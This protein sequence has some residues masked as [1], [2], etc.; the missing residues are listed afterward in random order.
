MHKHGG[1]RRAT[2]IRQNVGLESIAE[3]QEFFGLGGESFYN[4]DNNNQPF[5]T[6]KMDEMDFVALDVEQDIIDSLEANLEIVGTNKGIY[7][8]PNLTSKLEKTA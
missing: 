7:K 2:K 3:Q 4:V 6:L 5:Q 1:G 8:N